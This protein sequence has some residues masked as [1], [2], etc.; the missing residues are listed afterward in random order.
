MTSPTSTVLL[1]S[2]LKALPPQCWPAALRASG[3]CVIPALEGGIHLLLRGD[4]FQERRPAFTRCRDAVAQRLRN[5][6]GLGHALAVAAQSLGEFAVVARDVG[7][8]ELLLR[9]RH[10]LELHRHREIVEQDG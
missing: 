5:L 4:E 3:R 7:G 1:L 8:A 9:H 6:A 10:D 2:M